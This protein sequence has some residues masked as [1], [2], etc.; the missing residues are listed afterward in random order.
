MLPGDEGWRVALLLQVH[1]HEF[2]DGQVTGG[3]VLK[4]CEPD[5]RRRIESPEWEP[6]ESQPFLKSQPAEV[7]TRKGSRCLV[8]T[9]PLSQRGLAHLHHP[10]HLLHRTPEIM[11]PCCDQ[12]S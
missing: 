7:F 8:Q 6:T 4:L 12:E 3:R 9:S 10:D 2:I 11:H 5:R 1:A